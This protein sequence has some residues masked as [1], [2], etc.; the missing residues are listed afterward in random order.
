MAC[1]GSPNC[2]EEVKKVNKNSA[3][4]LRPSVF[5]DDYKDVLDLN[6]FV[7]TKRNNFSVEDVQVM[8]LNT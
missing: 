3:N 2:N 1:N 4:N 6:N 8:F 7:I 5:K